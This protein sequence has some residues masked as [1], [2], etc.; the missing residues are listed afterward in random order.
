MAV[1]Q[2]SIA[3]ARF[4]PARPPERFFIQFRGALRHA[5][6]L[7]ASLDSPGV[8]PPP[9]ERRSCPVAWPRDPGLR[10]LR[11]SVCQFCAHQSRRTELP[12]GLLAAR[13]VALGF[14]L[15]VR[16][17]KWFRR[18]HDRAGQYARPEAQSRSLWRADA[19]LA[20]TL[21][22]RRRPLRPQR[23]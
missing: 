7:A 22:D 5:R 9:P 13:L 1:L 14:R 15:S 2:A 17:R 10:Q 18:R 8:Q 3:A 21:A 19:D 23:E 4:G 12:G 20:A 16:R 11:F 6:A